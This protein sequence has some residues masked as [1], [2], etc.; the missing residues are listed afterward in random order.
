[1]PTTLLLAHQDFQ[2]ILPPCKDLYSSDFGSIFDCL[3]TCIYDI[4]TNWK[5][6][7]KIKLTTS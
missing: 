3:K 5:L 6:L 1:M 4:F 2:T 7:N